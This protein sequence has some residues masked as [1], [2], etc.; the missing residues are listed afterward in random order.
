MKLRPAILSPKLAETGSRFV[1]S[2]KSWSSYNSLTAS[3]TQSEVR[4]YYLLPIAKSLYWYAN[5]KLVIQWILIHQVNHTHYLN[6]NWPNS[7]RIKSM[8]M[9]TIRTVAVSISTN[10]VS[11]LD[12]YFLYSMCRCTVVMVTAATQSK[13]QNIVRIQCWDAFILPKPCAEV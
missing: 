4:F 6:K 13:I 3:L 2:C 1:P 9:A 10:V 5:K 12:W 8:E 7:A 11:G